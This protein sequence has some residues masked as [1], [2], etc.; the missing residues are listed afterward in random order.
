[1]LKDENLSPVYLAWDALDECAPGKPG[2]NNLLE[3]IS[4]KV[5]VNKRLGRNNGSVV[6][7]DVQNHVEPVNAYIAHKLSELQQNLLYKQEDIAGMEAEIRE[8]AQ[9]TYLWWPSLSETFSKTD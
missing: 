7:L 3:V 1:M 6:E 2:V 9:N 4:E 5:E 8:R